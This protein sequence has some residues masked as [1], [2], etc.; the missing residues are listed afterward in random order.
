MLNILGSNLRKLGY[1]EKYDLLEKRV[2][3][4]EENI[5]FITEV[6]RTVT[7]IEHFVLNNKVR[8]TTPISSLHNWLDQIQEFAVRIVEAEN[9]PYLVNEGKLR[10]CKQKLA[11]FQ[12]QCKDQIDL[13][14]KRTENIYSIEKI[15][16]L[17][18]I[19]NL[20]NEVASLISIHQGDEKE[21]EDLQ[22]VQRQLDLI[23]MHFHRMENIEMSD[24]EFEQIVKQCID[25]TDQV[26]SDDAPPLDVDMIYGFIKDKVK[27]RRADSS[28]EWMK[29]NV[30]TLKEIR[31]YDAQRA[32]RVVNILKNSPKFL[33]TD[34][35]QHV[36]QIIQ[37]CEDRLDK[38]E[39]EGLKAKFEAMSAEN[40]K[41]FLKVIYNYINLY[42]KNVN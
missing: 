16:S 33:S 4:V 8:D 11:S 36:K 2:T 37:G 27:Q 35:V 28:A 21:V 39:V 5:N 20:R 42:M 30:P 41:S 38:L 15:E 19:A 17:G 26:F 12:K 22:C 40:K 1:Q 3:I 23:D 29:R 7:D 6:K 18:Q 13:N 25:E 10:N 34:Q 24:T 9:R 31:N 32:V 14:R